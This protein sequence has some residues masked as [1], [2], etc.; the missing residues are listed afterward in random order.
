[1]LAIFICHEKISNNYLSFKFSV[2]SSMTIPEITFVFKTWFIR[3]FF[4]QV[5]SYQLLPSGLFRFSLTLQHLTTLRKTGRWK[6]KDKWAWLEAR[7][8]F[9][10]ASQSSAG[11]RSSTLRQK[12][13]LESLPG[14]LKVSKIECLNPWT[15]TNV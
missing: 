2:I 1:M 13:L 4:I 5:R 7:W 6:L 10:R 15:W 11:S 12:H 8:D 9:S 3:T 14:W